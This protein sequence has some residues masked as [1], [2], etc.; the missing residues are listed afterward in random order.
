MLWRW[1]WLL[2]LSATC[3]CLPAAAHTHLERSEPADHASLSA[4]PTT[5][6]L[7][8]SEPVRLSA[9]HLES[10][11][12]AQLPVKPLPKAELKLAKLALPALLPSRYTLVWRGVSAD[13]HVAS[14]KL[15]FTVN[16]KP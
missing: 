3:W 8:F 11:E 10:A 6:T 5:A 7:M 9:V 4:A 16:G 13:G 12:G 1:S 15:E 2:A 14:G